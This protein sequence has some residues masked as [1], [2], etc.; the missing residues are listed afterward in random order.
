[1]RRALLGVAF[2]GLGAAGA[3]AQA[4]GG[5]QATVDA[6]DG[7]AEASTDASMNDGAAGDGAVDSAPVDS[8]PTCAAPANA[9][10]SALCI[11]VTPEAIQFLA[12]DPNLDGK[13][14]L[15]ID[16]HDAPNPDAPDGAPLPALAVTSFPSLD[17]GPDAAE[18]D[19]STTIPVVR[20]DDLPTTV[21]PRVVFVDSRNRQSVGAGWWLGGYDLANGF[22]SPPVLLKPITLTVGQGTTIT[23]D[24]TALRRLHVT[25]TR[26]ATPVGNAQG[27][28]TVV[29]TPDRVPVMG[30]KLFGAGTNPCAKM[31][32]MQTAEVNGF[33]YGKGPYYATAIL[34]DFGGGGTRLAPGAL[35]SLVLDGGLVNPPSSQLAYAANAYVVTH[36]LDLDLAV[37]NP[38][39]GPDNVS[40]P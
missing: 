34:D 9:Q 22:G 33:V 8:G 16:V 10:R 25:L 12:N 19:L 32:G 17:A 23:I 26:S 29:A 4:C 21:Y 37:P 14:F 2:L 24:L 30:T 39:G 28:A 7:S 15:A 36:T 6:S 1:M 27:P 40:C 38:D 31:T 3:V 5:D 35:T 20:F 13:G 11:V 18:L